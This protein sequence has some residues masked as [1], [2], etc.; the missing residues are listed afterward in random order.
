MAYKAG[1]WWLTS[2]IPASQEEAEIG[3]IMVQGQPGQI[4]FARPHLQNSQRKMVLEVW[5]KQ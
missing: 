3:M 2:I 1:C 5:L 4:V